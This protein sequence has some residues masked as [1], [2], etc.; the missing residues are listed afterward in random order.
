MCIVR[1]VTSLV[2]V[3][4]EIGY[5]LWRTSLRK[6]LPLWKC[7]LK[8]VITLLPLP[9]ALSLPLWKCGLKFFI[10]PPAVE[11][12]PSLPLWKCGLKWISTASGVN[13]AMS[14]PLW[15]C[16][17]KC[18]K[19][20]SCY[21]NESVTSLVEVWIEIL[22]TIRISRMIPSLPLWKCGLK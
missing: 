18:N 20:V 16:G 10:L 19:T 21:R 11:S 13:A 4:I 9:S 15:K 1:S 5:L 2:E 8:Y 22:E 14:L 12:L 17:L 3:W 7:G 6:S